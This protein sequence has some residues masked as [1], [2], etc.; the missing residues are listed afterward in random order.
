MQ[1]KKLITLKHLLIKNKPCIG[2]QFN[3]D[4][5]IH[6]LIK[7]LPTP[8]WSKLYNMVYIPNTKAN[9]SLIFNK[10]RGVAWINCNYFY[11]DR[12]LN[13]DN[14]V[15]DVSWVKKRTV[16]QLTKT[17]LDCICKN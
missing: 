13:D 17:I 15:T 5:V 14:Y 11:Q 3:S 9:I 7:E 16:K 6:A 2:L 1:L 10:F 4:K 12:K 8:K